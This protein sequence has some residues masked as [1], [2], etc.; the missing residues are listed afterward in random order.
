VRAEEVRAPAIVRVGIE[1]WLV[2]IDV[3]T[4]GRFDG[5]GAYDGCV[6][7]VGEGRRLVYDA[8]AHAGFGYVGP[9]GR[10]A[11]VLA[12]AEVEVVDERAGLSCEVCRRPAPCSTHGRMY[13][14]LG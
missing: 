2:E 9:Y 11:V 8:V 3:G 5:D 1:G 14:R 13:A 12:D 4:V 10:Y 6:T 7:F